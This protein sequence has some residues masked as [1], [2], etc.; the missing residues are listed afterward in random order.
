MSL[1]DWQTWDPFVDALRRSASPGTDVSEFVGTVGRGA[2]QG[3]YLDDGDAGARR[4]HYRALAREAARTGGAG[5]KAELD[6]ALREIAELTPDTEQHVRVVAAARPEDD[7]VELFALPPAVVPGPVTPVLEVVLE[8]G[9]LPA[10][11]LATIVPASGATV[12]PSA[13]PDAVARVV[14]ERMPDAAGATPDEIAAAE[15][16]LSGGTHLPDEVRAL[17]A[18]AG[19]GNL[20]LAPEEGGFGGFEIVPLRGSFLREAFLPA[21]R[22]STWTAD[23]DTFAPEDPSGRVQAAI[24]SSLW[25][26]VGTDG[27]GNVYAAD[28][29]PGASGYVGQVVLLDHE[30]RA[31]AVYR[32]ESLAALLVG[33]EGSSGQPEQGP[34]LVE[35]GLDGS[36]QRTGVDQRAASDQGEEPDRPAEFLALDPAGWAERLDAGTVPDTLKAAGLVPDPARPPA[37]AETVSVANRLLDLYGLDPIAVTRVTRPEAKGLLDRIF[38]R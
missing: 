12:A 25:F 19:S 28:L 2:W 35:P 29:A 14:A 23:A 38:D 3:T 24:G 15:A 27:A 20:R 22:F 1:T 18:T 10:Q 36:D 9:A 7:V 31:G 32:S 11:H 8:P 34:N 5:P 13:D 33:R 30:M 37:P 16:D 17:Y 4:D 26:P 21:A 6:D